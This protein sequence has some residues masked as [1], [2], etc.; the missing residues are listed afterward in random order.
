MK[1]EIKN[2]RVIDPEIG[3]DQPDSVFIAGSKIVSVNETAP[4]GF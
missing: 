3:F 1:N 4:R 2:G